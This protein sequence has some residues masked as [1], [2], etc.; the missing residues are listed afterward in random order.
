MLRIRDNKTANQLITEVFKNKKTVILQNIRKPMNELTKNEMWEKF[1][2]IFH[3]MFGKEFKE[4]QDAI[5]N[6]KVLF[7]YFLQ[8]RKFFK[9]ENLRTDITIPSFQKGLLIIGGYGLGKTDYFKVFEKVFEKYA[10]YRFKFYTSKDLVTK[11]ELCQTAF[12]KDFFLKDVNRKRMFIDDISSERLASNYGKIDV[13][14]EILSNRYNK[15]RITFASCNYSNN[16]EC[17]KETIE[18]LGVR[19]GPRIY[20]R[21]YE[22]FNVIEFRGKSYRR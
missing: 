4:D 10:N 2:E 20:D 6:I 1:K 18:N 22:I 16:K 19:Y 7:Y 21:L 11:Y 8:D 5:Y 13:I 12:D 15:N 14:E 3:S 17:A 9:C